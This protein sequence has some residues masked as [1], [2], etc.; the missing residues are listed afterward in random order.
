[1]A[2]NIKN[3]AFTADSNLDSRLLNP[4]EKKGQ[5]TSDFKDSDSVQSSDS[6]SRAGDL[7]E[8]KKNNSENLSAS[9]APSLREAAMSAKR[10]EQ[11]RADKEGGAGRTVVA[12]PMRKGT[13]SLLR[14]A[15]INLI[16]SWG[17]TVIWINIHVFLGKVLG[18]KFFCKLGQE[19]MDRP[20]AA[21][22]S[23]NNSAAKE[24]GKIIGTFESMGLGCINLGCLMILIANIVLISL[25]LKILVNPIRTAL[26]ALG[27]NVGFNVQ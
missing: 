4:S 14:S 19:W 21:A 10:Q 13:S 18:N 3:T 8:S 27:L 26:E 20:G 7:R 1:M 9:V 23:K 11:S 22:A 24:A 25:I 15:W 5:E 6:S 12:A 16:P 17:L 2:D